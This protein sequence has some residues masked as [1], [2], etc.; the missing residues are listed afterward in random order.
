MIQKFVDKFMNDNSLE[1]WLAVNHPYSYRE[2]VKKVIEIISEGEDYD[3]PDP[4]TI[5]E[6]DDGN[7]QGTLLYVIPNKG[8][9]P[10]AYWCVKV[11]YGSCS[12]CDALYS[13]RGYGDEKP[14]EKQI[15]EYWSLALHI[16]QQLKEI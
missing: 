2:L 10:Y 6:I 1:K 5:H 13:I 9:Q 15:K 3:A 8:Y 12:V 4:K 7:Y 11:D 14:N 16:V